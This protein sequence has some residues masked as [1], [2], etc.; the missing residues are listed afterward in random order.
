TISKTSFV[1]YTG[2]LPVGTTTITGDFSSF[3]AGDVVRFE[4]ISGTDSVNAGTIYF[5]HSR[6]KS[7]NASQLVLIDPLVTAFGDP[8]IVPAAFLNKLNIL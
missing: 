1:K 5:E 6:V 2:S 8:F 7:A 3:S 4:N